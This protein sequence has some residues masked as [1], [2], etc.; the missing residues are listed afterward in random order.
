[1]NKNDEE[2]FSGVIT[3]IWILVIIKLL[4]LFLEVLII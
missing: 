1:M 4:V 2:F 3:G